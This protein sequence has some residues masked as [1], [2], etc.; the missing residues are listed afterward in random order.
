MN[1]EIERKFIE[2]GNVFEQVNTSMIEFLDFL[3]N[4]N[5]EDSKIK[6][7]T[8]ENEQLVK[9]IEYYQK[10]NRELKKRDL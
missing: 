9:G 4:E 10:E 1:D 5:M 7:L 3:K 2:L 8:E 6:Q